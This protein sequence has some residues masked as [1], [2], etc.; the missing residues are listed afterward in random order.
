MSNAGIVEIDVHGMNQHQARIYINST[1]KKAK[2]DVYRIRIIHGYHQGN[3][4]KNMI[5]KEYRHYPGVLSI[6]YGMNPGETDLILR[7]LF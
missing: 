2:S 7:K 3:A 5:R 6:E 1:I 4:L